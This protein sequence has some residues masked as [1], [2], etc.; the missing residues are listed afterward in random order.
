MFICTFSFSDIQPIT[1]RNVH[2]LFSQLIINHHVEC[3]STISIL[4]NQA[5]D[6]IYVYHNAVE[7][8]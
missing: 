3:F 5:I 8:S 1:I 6:N 7:R 4:G 2:C